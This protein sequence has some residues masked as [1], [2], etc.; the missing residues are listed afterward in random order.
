MPKPTEKHKPLISLKEATVLRFCCYA[1]IAE[2]KAKAERSGVKLDAE[3]AE[4]RDLFEKLTT[5]PLGD[6]D[7]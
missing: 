6:E 7:E 1:R 3:V 2:L 4:I 5:Y